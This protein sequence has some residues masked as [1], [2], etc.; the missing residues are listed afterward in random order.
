MPFMTANSFVGLGIEGTRGTASSNVKFVPVTTPQITPM[1]KWLRDDAFRSSP[2][3]NYGEV[4]GVRHDEYDFKGYVFA[5]TFG[6]LA[7]GALGYESVTGSSTYTHTIGLYNNAAAASQPPSV[8][9]Q[10]FD[11]D[12][13]FQ[14]LAGQVGDLNITFTAEGALEYDAKLMANPFTKISNPTT[15]FSTEVFIPAWDCAMTIGGTSTT[16]TAAGDINIKRNTAPIFTAQGVNSPYRLFAGP[17]DV[18]GKFTFVLESTDPILYNGSSNG[19]G[20][21]AGVQPVVLT[22]TDP[23]SSHTVKFQMTSV[24]FENPK[25]TRGKAYVEVETEFQAV[26]NTTDAIS[27]AGAGF[28]PIQ[29]VATNAVSA[30]Y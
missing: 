16:V 28:S 12:Q 14:L 11:G 6:I 15:S 2:V 9:V 27:G 18:S 24:Q 10:D 3:D 13:T 21:T 22:F 23:V 29:I 5:D 25:R 20:L 4:L 8:T 19:Y 30:A 1:Q 7:K 26:A 17:I